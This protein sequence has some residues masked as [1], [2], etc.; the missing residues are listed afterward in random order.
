[1]SS[2]SQILLEAANTHS[3]E[4]AVIESNGEVWSYRELLNLSKQVAVHVNS[5]KSSEKVHIGLYFDNNINFIASFFGVLLAGCVPLPIPFNSKKQE[6]LNIYQ[7]GDL[8]FCLTTTREFFHPDMKSIIIPELDRNSES[9]YLS[10][11]VKMELL[12]AVSTNDLALLLPTSGSTSLPKIVMLSHNNVYSNAIAHSN[13]LNLNENDMFLVS[14]PLYF[15]SAITTQLLSCIKSRTPLLLSSNLSTPKSIYKKITEYKVNSMAMVPTYLHLL[16]EY[17][18]LVKL[19]LNVNITTIV[20]SGAPLGEALFKRAN[21]FFPNADILQT[22]GL[23]E[24]S[25]RVSIMGR[26]SNGVLSCGKAVE[27]VEVKICEDEQGE[28]TL[29]NGQIGHIL[30]KGSNIMLGYY[31]NEQATRRAFTRDKWLCTGDLGYLDE[32][33][34][35]H[36]V[37]RSKNI[38]IVGGRNVYPEEI[39][40]KLAQISEI[41]EAAVT[42]DEHPVQGQI[43]VA[44]IVFKEG[45][46]L[47]KQHL[48]TELLPYLSNYKIPK[49]WVFVEKIPRTPTGKISRTELNDIIKRHS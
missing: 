29:D 28:H 38:I 14:M 27:G 41:K 3:N 24:A 13:A 39:E 48:T 49:V 34:N 30:I 32:S 36:L 1:M 40:E 21:L 33:S 10:E 2:I 16:I 42:Y 7:A 9:M 15:S 44:L 6:I 17:M 12:N 37:G 25:P 23:T 20:I 18:E 46:Y 43:P 45:R 22:Y 35:I 19:D 47:D 4:V 11:D 8:D 26:S 5:H 31:K